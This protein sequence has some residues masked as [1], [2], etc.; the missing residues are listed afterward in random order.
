MEPRRVRFYLE[1]AAP[2]YGALQQMVAAA[3]AHPDFSAATIA[4]ARSKLNGKIDGDQRSALR[5]GIDM[6][7][8]SF[9][10]NSDAG[11]PRYGM[12]ETLAAFSSADVRSFYAAHY[13]RG[14]AVISSMGNIADARTSPSLV[15][16]GLPAGSS[17]PI[18]V[19]AAPLPG[20]SRQIIARRD[21]PVPWLI[22]QY[23]APDISSKDFGAM[24]VL[25]QFMQR[26]LADV[27]DVPSIA[28]RSA[29]ERGVG[30]L[31]NFDASPANVIVY[32]DGGLGDPMRSFS[33][34]LGVVGVLGHAK[35]G[36]D[37]SDLKSFAIGRLLEDSQ[38]LQARSL[39]AAIFAEHHLGGDYQ[40]QLIKAINATT[41]ADLQRV[42]ARY[43]S[44]PTIALVLP[45]AKQ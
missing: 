38:S 2:S 36:G 5:V 44:A 29:S 7:N 6:L 35:L 30:T 43:L 26:T 17:S 9:Y 39:L 13:R 33:M 32:V 11:L 18:V 25:T 31:Y 16:A 14:D 42:A 37:L 4:D 23:H 45:R 40:T 3:L 21:V 22:A 12:S 28:T 20:T 15:A 41:A 27:S 1:G 34:A 10:E 8:R 24:L 19:R